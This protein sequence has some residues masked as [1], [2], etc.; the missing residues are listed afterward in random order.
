MSIYCYWFP[1]LLLWHDTFENC[2]DTF[3]SGT[4]GVDLRGQKCEN[5]DG[6]GHRQKTAINYFLP[7]PNPN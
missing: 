2:R 4:L 6:V 7:L 3:L 1:L 5:M